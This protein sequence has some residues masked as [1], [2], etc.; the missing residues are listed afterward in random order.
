VQPY[1]EGYIMYIT[2]DCHLLC[3]VEGT[4][5]WCWTIAFILWDGMDKSFEMC[6]LN[7]VASP[8]DE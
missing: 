4:A 6:H 7:Y 2:T 8:S 1:G 5:V 3:M